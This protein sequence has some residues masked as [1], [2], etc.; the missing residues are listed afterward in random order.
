M[1]VGTPSITVRLCG[2]PTY[3]NR[4]LILGRT[5]SGRG[6]MALRSC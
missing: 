2:S 3:R 5:E 4:H 6:F 1:H